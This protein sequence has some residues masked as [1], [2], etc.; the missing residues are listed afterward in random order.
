MISLSGA[1]GGKKIKLSGLS[2]ELCTDI[3][4]GKSDLG[5]LNIIIPKSNDNIIPSAYLI[6][7]HG[8]QIFLK[9]VH[10]KML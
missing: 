8:F 3:F 10:L 1:L 7:Q 4:V 5:L 9:T 6:L 2:K